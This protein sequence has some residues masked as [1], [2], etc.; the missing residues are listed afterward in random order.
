MSLWSLSC[1]EN[2]VKMVKAENWNG[3]WKIKTKKENLMKSFLADDL[4]GKFDE[5]WD[6]LR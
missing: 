1:D 4:N 6:D 5:I 3:W 2:A